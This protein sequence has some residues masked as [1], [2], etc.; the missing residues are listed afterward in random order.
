VE[1]SYKW[2]PE[3]RGT[4]I[5]ILSANPKVA[6]EFSIGVSCRYSGSREG[7]R[8]RDCCSSSTLI[9]RIYCHCYL[10]LKKHA[11]CSFTSGCPS[12]GHFNIAA[13]TNKGSSFSFSGLVRAVRGT[14]L[15]KI[16]IPSYIHY[17]NH[18]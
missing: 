3:P 8:M 2:S 11:K 13:S 18:R 14:Y 12:S 9:L 16:R 6:G 7:R 17:N 10:N 1:T 4:I 15:P 5:S